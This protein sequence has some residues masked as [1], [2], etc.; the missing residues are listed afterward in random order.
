M[1]SIGNGNCKKPFTQSL[2]VISWFTEV[3]SNEVFAQYSKKM[4][5]HKTI[6]AFT[7]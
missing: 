6:S 5:T 4:H 2:N 3:D 7:N 1:Q